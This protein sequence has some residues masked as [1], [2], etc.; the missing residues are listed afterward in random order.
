MQIEG[1]NHVAHT[2]MPR[3]G[4]CC[5]LMMDFYP[6]CFHYSVKL[7]LLRHF[8]TLLLVV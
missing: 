8:F 2:P 7:S 3:Q 5:W 6:G 4:Y 1:G